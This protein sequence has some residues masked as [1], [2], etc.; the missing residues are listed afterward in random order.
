[1]GAVYRARHVHLGTLC[2]VKKMHATLDQDP[3]ARERFRR[4]AH[5]A[6][7]IHHP[8]VVRFFDYAIREDGSALLIMEF[9]RGIDLSELLKHVTCPKLAVS[10]EIAHQTLDALAALHEM[11]V[12]HRDISPENLML[13]T[14]AS[15]RLRVKLI[16][17]GLAKAASDRAVTA[18]GVFVGK[19]KYGSPE[20]LG[21]A[22][23]DSLDGRSD[24]YSFAVVLYQLLTGRPPFESDSPG[25]W[26]FAHLYQAPTPFA[27]E[28]GVPEAVCRAVLRGLEKDPARRFP[29]ARAFA[30]ALEETR[31]SA[32]SE[33]L[34]EAVE[35]VNEVVRRK[36]SPD[37]PTKPFQMT[38]SPSSWPTVP[39]ERSRKE[40]GRF[41][42][43]VVAA[44]LLMVAG[45]LVWQGM[46]PVA[47]IP[48]PPTAVG[49]PPDGTLSVTATPWAELVSAQSLA[50]GA[51]TD[52]AGLV[53]PLFL[54]LRPGRYRLRFTFPDEHRDRDVDVR[55]EP[56][57]T[58]ALHVALEGYD[59]EQLV[60]AYVP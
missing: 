55:V 46:K 26:V 2:V 51:R 42:L 31:R 29:T 43:A 36:T 21:P 25:G 12:V 37:D 35:T 57:R 22:G 38:E 18:T 53:T 1:M 6:L 4:E 47:T 16:D 19:L 39:V 33:G 23:V 45:T 28:D 48:V 14:N 34:A 50:N 27:P 44:T 49:T 30:D 40:P 13:T 52:T 7:S 8:N 54:P 5:T 41:V 15:G 59:V 32:G 9:I 58:Q 20:Q 60:N 11:G 3:K 24:L 10:L 56:G 17:L